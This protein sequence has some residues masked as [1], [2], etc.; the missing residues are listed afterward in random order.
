MR[1]WQQK[2]FVDNSRRFLRKRTPKISPTLQRFPLPKDFSDEIQNSL[3]LRCKRSIFLQQSQVQVGGICSFLVQLF[4]VR[5]RAKSKTTYSFCNILSYKTRRKK[6][7]MAF[8]QFHCSK[9]A[10]FVRMRKILEHLQ[11]FLVQSKRKISCGWIAV[12]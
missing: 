12:K 3:F 9:F 11:T 5:V 6:N 10:M 7:D 4:I 8:Q 1:Q 2:R